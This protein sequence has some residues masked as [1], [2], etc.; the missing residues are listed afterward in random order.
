MNTIHK[1]ST[2]AVFEY[3]RRPEAA[4]F[5]AKIKPNS[6]VMSSDQVNNE[7][8]KLV[9]DV[10]KQKK[11]GINSEL[12]EYAIRSDNYGYRALLVGADVFTSTGN[13]SW[14]AIVVNSNSIV[15]NKESITK[16]SEL[17]KTLVYSAY[18][19]RIR[20]YCKFLKINT[21]QPSTIELL[22]ILNKKGYLNYFYG[23]Y[24]EYKN[25][26]IQ[27][28]ISLEHEAGDPT[29][30]TS[31]HKLVYDPHISHWVRPEHLSDEDLIENELE[32][33]PEVEIKEDGTK[34]STSSIEP[35]YQYDVIDWNLHGPK[36]SQVEW[37]EPLQIKTKKGNIQR[38]SLSGMVIPPAWKNVKI[39]K[40]PKGSIQV[41]GQDKKGQVAQLRSNDWHDIR[42]KV[43]YD[44]EK[45]FAKKLPS[46]YERSIVL[47]F[48]RKKKQ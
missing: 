20:G 2:N 45:E 31:S 36:T 30:Y 48:L 14:E 25:M 43:K 44:R 1:D 46:H 27:K 15:V 17:N 8:E 18:E 22:D 9:N 10:E 42:S 35:D 16:L 39:N 3:A 5:D 24:P 21:I 11:L 37:I 47:T 4:I 28:S 34:D 13:S 26:K 38:Q 29:D 12:L 33:E 32:E 40:D 41:T 7:F 6:V 19:S 23:K